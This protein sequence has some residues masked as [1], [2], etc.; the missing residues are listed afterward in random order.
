VES[1]A[2]TARQGR[3]VTARVRAPEWVVGAAALALAANLFLVPWYGSSGGW[4]SLQ[5][6]RYVV[7]LCAAGGLAVLWFQGSL[8]APAVPV[9]AT[10]IE[11]L[12]SGLTLA[13]LIVR[14]AAGPPSGVSG[15]PLNGGAYISMALT[16]TI[17]VGAYLSLRRDG[18]RVQDGPG[19]I[20]HLPVPDSSD[21]GRRRLPAAD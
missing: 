17:A 18:I 4:S 1:A 14:L 6:M 2:A 16:A 13:G 10:A 20:E 15:E 3:F 19:E 5:W 11:L 8:G 7:L 21:A 12:V 9:C